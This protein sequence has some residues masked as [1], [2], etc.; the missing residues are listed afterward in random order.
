MQIHPPPGTGLRAYLTR[1]LPAQTLRSELER[2]LP[3][4]ERRHAAHPRRLNRGCCVNVRG[5]GFELF[6]V[7]GPAGPP[8]AEGTEGSV[9]GLLK[10][11]L[12]PADVENGLDLAAGQRGPRGPVHRWLKISKLHGVAQSLVLGLGSCCEANA[13][14]G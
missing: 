2:S 13:A 4:D 8:V 5:G 10:I 9:D 7:H 11:A 3:F 14:T 6:H 1:A 12:G